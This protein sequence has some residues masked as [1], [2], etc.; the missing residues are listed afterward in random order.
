VAEPVRLGLVGAGAIA[1]SYV[2]A[3]EGCDE[4][5]LVAV[6]DNRAEA[7]SA[8]AER[9]GCP[10]YPSYQAMALDR[11]RFDAIIV[12]TPP[13]THEE[14]CLHFVGLKVHV[15]CEKPFAVS[16]AGAR[17]MLAASRQAG[18]L[19][20]MGSKF[21]YV[22]DVIRAKSIVQSGV[23][24]DVIL[25]ENAFTSRVAMRSRWNSDPRVSG[26]GVLIDNGSHSV[27]LMR[28]F[29]GPLASLQVVEGRRVQGLPVEDTAVIFARSQLGVIGRIDL[30]WSVNKE[31]ESYLNI[32]GTDG[33]VSVGWKQ[34]RFRQ[35]TSPDWATFGNG[36]DKVQAFRGQIR[37]FVRAVRGVEPL[38]IT[39]E[40]AVASVEVIEA[41][42]HSLDRENWFSIPSVSA[43]ASRA[44]G[45]SAVLSAVD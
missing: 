37:N 39:T 9:F 24:G 36:Y 26:G 11:D 40:D 28:Y 41:A 44:N 27:D 23:L 3:I 19:L 7:A 38:L 42:Y 16:A 34:S 32:Y 18:V 15:L 31:L 29:L 22:D 4:A 30:S 33:V 5:R 1:Q 45:K 14:I 35:N 25:F 21:R 13:V 2:Q 10:S 12:C 8:I 43:S 17:R 6:A 20:T